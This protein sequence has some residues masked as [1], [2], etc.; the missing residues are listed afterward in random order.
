MLAL[1]YRIRGEI[2][3]REITKCTYQINIFLTNDGFDEFWLT[4]HRNID[5]TR[6]KFAESSSCTKDPECDRCLNQDKVRL[7]ETVFPDD[8]QIAFPN[9]VNF[10]CPWQSDNQNLPNLLTA[11]YGWQNHLTRFYVDPVCRPCRSACSHRR[12]NRKFR[13]WLSG[14]CA[15]NG[16]VWFFPAWRILPSENGKY[17]LNRRKGFWLVAFFFSLKSH[18]K[19]LMARIFVEGINRFPINRIHQHP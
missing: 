14:F 13:R 8:A 11:L 3:V 5:L 12:A 19:I 6:H 1:S 18:K 16:L 4:R 15:A 9:P 10:H 2:N 17:F 7:F